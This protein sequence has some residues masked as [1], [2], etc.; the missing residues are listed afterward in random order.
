MLKKRLLA[1]GTYPNQINSLIEECPNEL[2]EKA[3]Y[4]LSYVEQDK[5]ENAT[6][7]KPKA[8]SYSWGGWAAKELR[9]LIKN[10]EMNPRLATLSEAI[11]SSEHQPT[12]PL[13]INGS[14]C[15]DCHGTGY[16]YPAGTDKGVA[17][18]KH[19]KLVIKG[20]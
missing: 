10:S 13:D 7:P 16:W 3:A 6:R 12:L 8:E 15:P 18:C 2:L 1:L 5:R 14:Q 20:K 17:R 9:Y 4:I 11:K 19:L